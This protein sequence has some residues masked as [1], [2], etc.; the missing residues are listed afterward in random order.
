ME[1]SGPRRAAVTGWFVL[2][3]A[4]LA[5]E[6][7]ARYSDVNLSSGIVRGGR[8]GMAMAEVNWYLHPNIKWRFNYG[9]GHLSDRN[10]SGN[11]NVFQTRIEV[12]F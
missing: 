10:P 6:V 5:W 4:L 8:L 11:F 2:G 7:A 12:D 3:L 9:F 1:A